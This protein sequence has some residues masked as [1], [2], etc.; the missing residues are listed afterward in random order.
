MSSTTKYEQLAHVKLSK[1]YVHFLRN[2]PQILETARDEKTTKLRFIV[3]FKELPCQVKS[4]RHI[5]YYLVHIFLLA[6]VLVSI[7][8]EICPSLLAE[9][10]TTQNTHQTTIYPTKHIPASRILRHQTPRCPYSLYGF[11]CC[12]ISRGSSDLPFIWTDRES[13]SQDFCAEHL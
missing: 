4:S 13:C 12:L 1:S 3:A 9:T 2:D 11:K 5:S 8:C 6:M 7:P 10:K